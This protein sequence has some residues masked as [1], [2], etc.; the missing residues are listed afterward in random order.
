MEYGPF[1]SVIYGVWPNRRGSLHLKAASR[2]LAG[3][4]IF[5]IRVWFTCVTKTNTTV[6]GSV[7]SVLVRPRLDVPL[8]SLQDLGQGLYPPATRAQL[9]LAGHELVPQM[10]QPGLEV[11]LLAS[12]P[13]SVVFHRSQLLNLRTTA[14]LTLSL[15]THSKSKH[16]FQS[17]TLIKGR[18][19]RDHNRVFEA[20]FELQKNG[21]GK[22]EH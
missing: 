7:G 15:V 8:L 6:P 21:T 10:R 13:L 18:C 20:F 4:E 17:I 5:T 9:G 12:R 1:A 22:S 2:Q 16:H 19:E 14:T 11:H 3:K